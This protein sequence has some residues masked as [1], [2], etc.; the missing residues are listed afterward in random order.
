[1]KS[2]LQS[3][4]KVTQSGIF[5]RHIQIRKEGYS[6]MDLR[7][8][9]PTPIHI[10]ITSILGLIRINQLIPTIE[11]PYEIIRSKV[12]SLRVISLIRSITSLYLRMDLRGNSNIVKKGSKGRFRLW[13]VDKEMLDKEKLFIVEVVSRVRKVSNQEE[14]SNPIINNNNKTHHYLTKT[15]IV[16]IYQKEVIQKESLIKADNHMSSTHNRIKYKVRGVEMGADN[17]MIHMV[18][19]SNH[20]IN[21]L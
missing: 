9:H 11:K 7:N 3:L 6:K 12:K 13:G 18:I 16:P 21:P 1:M 19:L 5:R 15:I 14:N 2:H 17:D 20:Y 4:R 8:F 10:Q